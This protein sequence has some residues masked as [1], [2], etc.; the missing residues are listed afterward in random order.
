MIAFVEGT[1]V[2]AGPPAVVAVGGGGVGLALQ[3]TTRASRGAAGA[4]ANGC[5]FW[6]HLVAREDGWT[7]YGFP[8]REELALFRLLIGVNGVGPKLAL[9]ALSGASPAEIVLYLRT[10]DEK[11]LIAAAGHRAQDRRAPRGGAGRARRAGAGRAGAGGERSRRG[12]RPAPIRCARR[13]RCSR[14]W[15]CRRRGP[16][17][18]CAPRVNGT[19]GPSSTWRTGCVGRCASSDRAKEPCE[20]VHPPRWTDPSSLPGDAEADA[21]LR[22]RRLA[23]FVGQE[24][25]KANLRVFIAAARGA[26]RGARPRPA[27]RSARPGQDHARRHHRQRDGARRSTTPADRRSRTARN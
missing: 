14:R 1:L 2:E 10:G 16:S 7:L 27:L 5:G 18:R 13:W 9:G 11:S 21:S 12:R 23:D 19:P 15:V 8:G 6:T 26:G 17:R 22:P 3:L 24:E 20:R 25:V 4:G